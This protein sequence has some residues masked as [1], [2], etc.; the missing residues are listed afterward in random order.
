M[1]QREI[2]RIDVS[3]LFALRQGA[4]AVRVI[5]EKLC[6]REMGPADHIRTKHEVKRFVESGDPTAGEEV[7]QNARE[8][9]RLNQIRTEE[10]T[11]RRGQRMA[12]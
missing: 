8:R 10:I 11:Q 9:L 12:E 5:T 4:D 6:V 2:P 3:I 1:N 7:L